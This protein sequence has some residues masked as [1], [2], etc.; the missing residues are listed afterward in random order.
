MLSL[1]RDLNQQ[2]LQAMCGSNT[3]IS[4]GQFQSQMQNDK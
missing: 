3:M 1:G 4:W 2:E